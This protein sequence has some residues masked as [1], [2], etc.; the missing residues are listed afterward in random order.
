MDE[1]LAFTIAFVVSFIGTLPP[2]SLNIMVIQLGLEHKISIAWRFAFAA[3][4]VEYPYAWVAVKFETLITSSPIITENFQIITAVVMLLLG[5]FSL[6]TAVKKTSTANKFSRSG[7]RRGLLLA[8]LNPMALPFWVAMTAYIRSRGWT[9]LSDNYELQFYLL[10]VCLGTLVAFMMFAY[11]ARSVVKYFNESKL[12]PFIPGVS[13]LA[14]A[15]YAFIE[16]F[17]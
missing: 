12:L 15:L 1:I 13:L 8:V 4:I 3:T 5:I 7:F 9:D 2:G 16:Y 14:L 17:V 11:L 10:G 6:L